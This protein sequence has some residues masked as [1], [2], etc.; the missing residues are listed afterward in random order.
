MIGEVRCRV[1]DWLVLKV[2]EMAV[3]PDEREAVIAPQQC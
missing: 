2:Q 3:G 1:L